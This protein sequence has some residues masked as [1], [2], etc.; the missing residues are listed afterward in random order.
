MSSFEVI[1]S[2]SDD[3]GKFLWPHPGTA[4]WA[5]NAQRPLLAEEHV[6]FLWVSEMRM[7]FRGSSAICKFVEFPLKSACQPCVFRQLNFAFVDILIHSL[8][9]FVCF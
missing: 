7:S 1:A 6:D 4:G 8:K 5:Q 3:I 9:G 2:P